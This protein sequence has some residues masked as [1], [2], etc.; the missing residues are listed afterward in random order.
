M[1]EEALCGFGDRA[2]ELAT[3]RIGMAA[4]M[5][6]VG[7]KHIDRTVALGTE[8]DLDLRLG[9]ARALTLVRFQLILAH[10]TRITHITYLE[11]HIDY[12]LGITRLETEAIEFLAA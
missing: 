11:R 4:A 1:V 8:R 5:E 12:S 2:V 7:S 10:E 6:P 9:I 3:R